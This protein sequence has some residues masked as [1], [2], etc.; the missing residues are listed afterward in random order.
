MEEFNPKKLDTDLKDALRTIG[1]NIKN[2]RKEIG[3]TQ[4][5]L[6]F[7]I[8]SDKCL[9]SNIERGTMGNVTLCTL[10]KLANV[11]EIDIWELFSYKPTE[12]EYSN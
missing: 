5:T 9:I 10:M 6:A 7:Y 4:Q 12:Q 11:F 8:L 1:Q 2:M 3:I